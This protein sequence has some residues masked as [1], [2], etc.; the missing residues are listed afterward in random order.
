[1]GISIKSYYKYCF[2]EKLDFKYRLYILSRETELSKRVKLAKDLMNYA[3]AHGI[4]IYSCKEL[5]YPFLELSSKLPLFSDINYLPNSFLHVMTQ[6][7]SIGGHSRVVERWIENSPKDQKHSIFILNQKQTAYTNKLNDIINNHDGEL[8]LLSEGSLIDKA[9]NLRRIAMQY[10]FIIL[11]IHMDDPTPIVAFGTEDFTRPVILFNHSDHQ[12][13]CGVSIVD[14]L[15]DLREND[16]AKNRRGIKNVYPLYIPFEPN[17]NHK[18]YKKS[19]RQSRIDLGLPLDKKILLTVGGKHKFQPIAGC[20][21]CDLIYEAINN[22]ND[23][24]CYGIGPNES[25]GNWGKYTNKFVPVGNIPYGEIYFDYINACDIYINSFPLSG[26]TAMLD[27]I[28]FKKP[29]LSF[30]LFNTGLGDIIKGIE[31]F[32]NKDQFIKKLHS[33]ILSDNEISKLSELEYKMVLKYHGID[34][35]KHNLERMITK[36]PPKHNIHSIPNNLDTTI[37]DLAIKVALWNNT[38]NKRKLSIYDIYHQFKR[39]FRL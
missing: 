10:E 37:D 34:A 38:L 28:Q 1:M 5:E 27:A 32:Y 15:A 8:F 6:A 12:F 33:L 19:K 20:E 2:L 17:L 4:G 23:V 35:W 13:W 39:I 14:L 22:I 25:I 9:I 26:G 36:I 3:V 24:V 21:F 11:H 7:Y 31:T 30:S 16:F 18:E 29:V